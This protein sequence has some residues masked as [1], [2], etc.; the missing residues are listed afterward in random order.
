MNPPNK[1]LIDT[2]YFNEPTWNY[3]LTPG[4]RERNND[5]M[6][7]SQVQGKIMYMVRGQLVQQEYKPLIRNQ[8]LLGDERV[9]GRAWK[10]GEK[11]KEGWFVQSCGEGKPTHSS[12]PVADPYLLVMN[13]T[14]TTSNT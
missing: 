13:L 12:V 7:P 2:R 3:S 9:I 10:W 5:E 6:P 4:Q 8:V 1:V 14:S 11:E